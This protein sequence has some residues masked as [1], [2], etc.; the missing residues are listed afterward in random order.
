[1]TVLLVAKVLGVVA[2]GAAVLF[3][4]SLFELS[5]QVGRYK[6]YWQRNNSRPVN[7]SDILYVALG[8]STAQGIGASHPDKSYPG[9][10]KANLAEKEGQPVHLVNLSKSGAKIKD[11][12]TTQ[13]PAMQKLGINEKTVIT[14]EIGANDIAKFEPA[15]FESEMDELMSKLPAQTV[16]SDIPYFGDGRLHNK[17]PDV[18]AA[19]TIM[20]KLAAKHGFELAP[21][22]AKMKRNG[23]IKTF[24]ADWFH[25][26]NYAYRENWAPV[27]LEKINVKR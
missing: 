27:F 24:A 20:Y 11:V 26:S 23:G 8:D 21:L 12:L 1:M 6:N 10:I 17:E 16:I 25:P 19:N 13:L 22:H 9:V 4:F 7:P 2:L 14:I 3:A 18:Q 5:T 15:K